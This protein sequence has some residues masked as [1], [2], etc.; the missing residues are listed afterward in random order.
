MSALVPRACDSQLQNKNKGSD[1]GVPGF[2]CCCHTWD[3]YI[4]NTHLFKKKHLIFVLFGAFLF[5]IAKITS[6]AFQQKPFLPKYGNFPRR[7]AG[8][9]LT[10]LARLR[11]PEGGTQGREEAGKAGSPSLPLT[12][13][14]WRGAGE[15]PP[16]RAGLSQPSRAGCAGAGPKPQQPLRPLHG[17]GAD[18][19]LTSQGRPRDAGAAPGRRGGARQPRGSRSGSLRRAATPRRGSLTGSLHGAHQ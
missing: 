1:L 8:T 13:A 15:A 3:P 18:G 19:T 9:P 11:F 12:V 7:G 17:A 4:A 6:A 10:P 5:N 14:A 16:P 2:C